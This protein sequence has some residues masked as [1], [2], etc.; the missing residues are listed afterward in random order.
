MR[1][2]WPICAALAVAACAMVAF[3]ECGTP[4]QM[5]EEIPEVIDCPTCD[6]TVDHR[7]VFPDSATTQEH[8]RFRP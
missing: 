5:V 4:L 8:G 3:S 6:R 1:D 7:M 2:Y